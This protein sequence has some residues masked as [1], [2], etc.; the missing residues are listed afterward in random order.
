MAVREEVAGEDVWAVGVE[1]IFESDE[2]KG[3]ETVVSVAKDE[4]FPPGV[5][6]AEIALIGNV[7]M[8]SR[9]EG[10]RG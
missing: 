1:A 7:F 5:V 8:G 4:E 2:E 10:K 6:G 9:K 3:R